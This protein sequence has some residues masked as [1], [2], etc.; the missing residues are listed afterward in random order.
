MKMEEKELVV[1]ENKLKEFYDVMW[2]EFYF[3]SL[4]VE[5]YFGEK[6]EW[7]F[8]Y[9]IGIVFFWGNYVYFGFFVNGLMYGIG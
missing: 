9:G 7:G 1:D 2:N 3:I 6:D 4:I 8:F 5:L